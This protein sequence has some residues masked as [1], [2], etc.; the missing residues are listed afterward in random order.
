MC[1]ARKTAE[2][3][4]SIVLVPNVAA[5]RYRGRCLE[6]RQCVSDRRVVS[7]RLTPV[8]IDQPR[9]VLSLKDDMII[10]IVTWPLPLLVFGLARRDPSVVALVRRP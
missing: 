1:R 5:E 3:S 4:L 2:I 8:A 9:P 10:G 6:W 7:E